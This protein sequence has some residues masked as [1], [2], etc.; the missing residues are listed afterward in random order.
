MFTV[1]TVC[2]PSCANCSAAHN[3]VFCL[4]CPAG[5]KLN[6]NAPTSCVSVDNPCNGSTYV[7]SDGSCSGIKVNN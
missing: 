5:M 4:T 3:P 1:L 7:N 2:D 6:G